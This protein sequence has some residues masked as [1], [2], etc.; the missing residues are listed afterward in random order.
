MTSI[1]LLYQDIFT[2]GSTNDRAWH[3]QNLVQCL[4]ASENVAI[5][6]TR[7]RGVT[8]NSIDWGWRKLCPYLSLFRFTG[9]TL[10]D[11][12]AAGGFIHF[13]AWHEWANFPELSVPG[14]PEMWHELT[15]TQ[16]AKIK[17]LLSGWRRGG[18]AITS[19]RHEKRKVSSTKKG[20][21]A[22]K[23]R[24]LRPYPLNTFS[25]I[26]LS[27]PLQCNCLQA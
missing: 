18:D 17:C 19:L 3:E 9:V 1:S 14:T 27:V 25:S 20:S 8:Y 26:F 16:G 22:K 7:L 12:Q 15:F 4:P 11:G 13:P 23:L 2:A 6:L 21:F 10:M 24:H 5:P